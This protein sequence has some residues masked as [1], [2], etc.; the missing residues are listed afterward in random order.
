MASVRS[1]L[2]SESEGELYEV[3][4]LLGKRTHNGKVEYLIRWK[5]CRKEDDSWEPVKNL[6][7]CQPLIKHFNKT[8]SPSP[9]RK[10]KTPKKS[11]V[12]QK[13]QTTTTPK[14]EE[15]T[16][17]KT[18]STQSSDF[19]ILHRKKGPITY[20]QET[21]EEKEVEITTKTDTVG[22][23]KIEEKKSIT[24]EEPSKPLP[25][26]KTTAV[27]VNARKEV[28]KVFAALVVLTFFILILFS[29]FR[30]VGDK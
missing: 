27:A 5:G 2:S 19:V 8:R 30:V 13:V 25:K 24:E 20:K 11:Q 15:Y 28:L 6:K 7:G 14:V 10:A 18:P 17:L 21:K 23:I 22:E 9:G 4:K 3:E 12:I 26:E 1:P 29:F 16:K